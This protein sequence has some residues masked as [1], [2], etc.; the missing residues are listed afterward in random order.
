MFN[1]I[2]DI[3]DSP[4][5]SARSTVSSTSNNKLDNFSSNMTSPEHA[6]TNDDFNM[7]SGGSSGIGLNQ[8]NNDT[9]NNNKF[10]KVT[11]PR[12]PVTGAGIDMPS[13]YQRK[14]NFRK[15]I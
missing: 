11:S 13:S 1:V 12:N 2:S 10:H 8:L 3:E 7:G 4:I 5:N 9:N 6:L 14:M 15:G